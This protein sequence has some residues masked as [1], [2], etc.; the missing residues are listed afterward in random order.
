MVRIGSARIDENGKISGGMPGDQTGKEVSIQ[1]WYPHSK[2]WIVLREKDN[3]ARLSIAAA[4]EAACAND[5]IG[6]NQS[7]NGTLYAIVKP[8][9]YNPSLVKTPCSTDCAKLV[10]VCVLYAG[11]NVPDFYTGNERSVLMSTGKFEMLNAPKYTQSS[12]YLLRG[13][14]LVTASKGHT[15]VV[16]DDGPRSSQDNIGKNS[17]TANP[18]KAP[19]ETIR[20]G[21]S[22]DGVRWM[23]TALNL[24]GGYGL[25]VD[26]EAGPLT[27]GA[28]KNFQK[29]VFP[30]DKSQWD[31][32]CGPKTKA[33]LAS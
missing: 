4:M 6:Y 15:A 21:S 10:R 27:I 22:G 31:G 24:K 33:K 11:I 14:I 2:G 17:T 1:P 9:G 16:L 23:Q 29:Q 8:L 26:G 5:Y 13:D 18:Y 28:L 25:I 20:L 3:F 32:I 12:D 30:D 19:L 7:Q